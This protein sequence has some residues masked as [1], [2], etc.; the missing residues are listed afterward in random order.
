MVI[1][2]REP[3]PLHELRNTGISRCVRCFFSP[4]PQALMPDATRRVSGWLGLQVPLLRPCAG[5]SSAPVSAQLR[6][7]Q[8]RNCFLSKN[9]LNAALAQPGVGLQLARGLPPAWL[10]R[11]RWPTGYEHVAP[12]QGETAFSLGALDGVLSHGEGQAMDTGGNYCVSETGLLHVSTTRLR[13]PGRPRAARCPRRVP[14][15]PTGPRLSR[16]RWGPAAA[17]AAPAGPGPSTE[18]RQVTRRERDD[19]GR[20]RGGSGRRGSSSSG[21][22]CVRV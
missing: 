2:S 16:G 1:N 3:S 4:G 13:T 21:H 8:T 18:H 14:A 15:S 20:P 17:S 6:T 19:L 7:L 9:I 22:V 12:R 11:P 5:H 10:G